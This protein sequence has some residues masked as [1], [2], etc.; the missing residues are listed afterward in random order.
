MAII[1]MK[2]IIRGEGQGLSSLSW[3]CHLKPGPYQDGVRLH[4][5]DKYQVTTQAVKAIT[6]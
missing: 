5:F 3:I 6:P 1:R 2:K 4:L